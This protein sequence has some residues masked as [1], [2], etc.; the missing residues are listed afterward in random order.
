MSQLRFGVTDV[1][2]L[3]FAVSPLWETVSSMWVVDDPVRNAVHLPWIDRARRA[4][5]RPEVAVRVAPLRELTR[6]GA[7]P[8]DFLTPPSPSP[9]ATLAD[10]LTQLV[11]TPAVVVVRDTMA[12]AR[13]LP[14]GPFGQRLVD[15]PGTALPHLASAVR[16]WY[17][18]VIAEDWARM[19]T[20]LE[21]D[22]AYRAGLLAEAG[23]GGFLPHLHPTVRWIGDRV[24]VDD[25]WEIDIDL[26][27]RGLAL[28]PGVFVG[29][30]V[31]WPMLADS[32][33]TGFYPVRA[34]G[35]L[36][37]RSVPADGDALSRV[38][39][40]SRATLLGLVRTPATTSD[41]ARRTGLS[42]GSVSQHLGA[43]LGAGLVSR[44]R[45]GQRVYYRGTEAADVLL[46]SSGAAD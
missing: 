38:L 18:E 45:R 24:I 27:G 3:R 6:R 4:L 43:L 23:V 1:A 42:I 2:K 10:Q 15:D 26:A 28:H 5:R 25:P 20:L 44:S 34:V 7:W 39:G 36:W 31:L 9:A 12:T 37:E 35:T 40:T 22:I 13:I 8:P 16:T 21:A 29:R 41:L 19:R 30:R 17:D 46:R 32:T 11:D 14:L 33:P